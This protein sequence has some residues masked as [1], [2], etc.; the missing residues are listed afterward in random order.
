MNTAC[1]R[2][3]CFLLSLATNAK[4][5]LD[6][7]RQFTTNTFS[8]D[9]QAFVSYLSQQQA[10]PPNGRSTT[11]KTHIRTIP[12]GRA[13]NRRKH[14]DSGWSLVAANAPVYVNGHTIRV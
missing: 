4:G 14:Y 11:T 9:T 1:A 10:I 13:R 7:F 12:R 2:P 3:C 8:A 5:K 6:Y